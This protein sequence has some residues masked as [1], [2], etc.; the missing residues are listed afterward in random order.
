M[1]SFVCTQSVTDKHAYA[2][3][4]AKVFGV[5]L[6]LLYFNSL[7]CF[8]GDIYITQLKDKEIIIII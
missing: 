2:L 5:K 6:I 3:L 1:D 7:V 8:Y 4:Y